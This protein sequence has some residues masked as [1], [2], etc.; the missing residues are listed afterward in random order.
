MTY[1]LKQLIDREFSARKLPKFD[2]PL[3]KRL[4]DEA[5]VHLNYCIQRKCPNLIDRKEILEKLGENFQNSKSANSNAKPICIR[6][7]E[8]AG[9][10][11]ILCEIANQ[12]GAWLGAEPVLITR[13]LNMT[14]AIEMAHELLL[15]ICA[16]IAISYDLDIGPCKQL[17]TCEK[18]GPW[19][20]QILETVGKEK[21]PLVILIDDLHLLKTGNFTGG[22]GLSWMPTNLPPNVTIVVTFA[23]E[24]QLKSSKFSVIDLPQ[25][26]DQSLWEISK[27]HLGRQQRSLTPDQQ[28]Y[29]QQQLKQTPNPTLATFFVDLAAHWP[30]NHSVQN[31]PGAL[32]VIL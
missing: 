20:S 11:S 27:A 16:Q 8:G 18:L 12:A 21:T 13:F 30:S 3:R 22:S 32:T 26:S 25:L 29:I 24:H 4:Y 15:S 17:V 28:R 14:P 7:E 2:D 10:T 1:K 6:G 19:F 9:K 5:L 23:A 31:G